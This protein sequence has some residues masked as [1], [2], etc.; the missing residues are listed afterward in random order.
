MAPQQTSNLKGQL[1]GTG[2]SVISEPELRGPDSQLYVKVGDI[3]IWGCVSH[4]TLV[5]M[6]EQGCNEVCFERLVRNVMAIDN[7]EW[8][9]AN[10]VASEITA[11]NLQ[12]MFVATLPAKISIVT[13]V[14]SGIDSI[15]LVFSVKLAWWFNREFVTTDVPEPTDLQLERHT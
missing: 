10:G 13:G 3:T 2:T 11:V 12:G 6:A 7:L 15:P 14:V 1:G 9:E 4:E 5:V 8:T